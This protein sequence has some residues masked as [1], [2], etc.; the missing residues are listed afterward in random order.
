[1]AR[2]GRKEEQ[3]E[4]DL[5]KD[6]ADLIRVASA[7]PVVLLAG[8]SECFPGLYRWH[9]RQFVFPV[10]ASAMYLDV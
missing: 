2:E 4:L 9:C 7:G 5:V 10:A 3:L 1:M 8:G 6:A